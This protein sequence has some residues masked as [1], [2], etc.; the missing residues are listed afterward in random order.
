MGKAPNSLA[1]LDSVSHLRGLEAVLLDCGLS[2]IIS[3]MEAIAQVGVTT[4]F[5]R[6]RTYP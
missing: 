3:C 4:G 5:S 2:L 1:G 6:A